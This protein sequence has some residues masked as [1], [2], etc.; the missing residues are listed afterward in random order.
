MAGRRGHLRDPGAH[1]ASTDHGDGNRGRE[2]RH[3]RPLNVGWRF[4]MN[5]A[6]PSR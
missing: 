1:G 3:Y 4:S 5:A 2:R 6:T